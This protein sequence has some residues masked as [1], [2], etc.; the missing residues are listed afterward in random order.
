MSALREIFA[1]FGVAFEAGPLKEGNASVNG[2]IG[3]LQE[4]GEVVAG[5]A[6]VNG[7]RNFVGEIA[8]V[9]DE[10]D[11]S[12]QALGLSTDR[13][14]EWRAAAGHAGV[15]VEQLT[16]ALQAVRRNA[17]AARMGSAGMASDFR[18]LGVTL[19]DE[20]GNLRSTDDLMLQIADGIAAMDDPTRQAAIAMRLM[21]ESGARLLPLFANGAAG[22]NEAAEAFRALGGGMSEE[23]IAA[24]AEYTDRVQDLNDAL[25]GI[26]S[27]IGVFVLPAVTRLVEGMTRAQAVF[28][29]LSD[30]GRLLETTMI[31]IGVASTAAGARTALAWIRAAAPFVALGLLIAGLVLVVEDLWVGFEG[32]DSVLAD[33]GHSFETWTETAS[34]AMAPVVT[35]LEYMKGLI[36]SLVQGVGLVFGADILGDAGDSVG[37]EGRPESALAGRIV[38]QRRSQTSAFGEFMM[39]DTFER[40]LAVRDAQSMLGGGPTPGDLRGT[41]VDRSTR[42]EIGRI[43]TT[44]MTP[45]EAARMVEGAVSRALATQADDVE[46]ALTQ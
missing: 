29:R 35:A 11:K 30:R 31:A 16:P 14:Q 27:R 43:D 44:G 17:D 41:A 3:R 20:S 18:R 21:G 37:R 9:G 4:L 10:L 26:K 36:A 19:R 2:L 42:V 22:V 8:H 28:G 1:R 45:Q 40:F 33:L 13:L 24:S 15:S 32:G 46:D 39:P 5:A 7:L 25:T 23:A 38:A 34:E 12:S 6:I